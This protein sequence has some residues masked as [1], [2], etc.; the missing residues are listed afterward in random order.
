MATKGQCAVSDVQKALLRDMM[1]FLDDKGCS[2]HT[3]ASRDNDELFLLVSIGNPMLQAQEDDAAKAFANHRRYRF[4]TKFQTMS[5]TMQPTPFGERLNIH[6]RLNSTLETAYL[7]YNQEWVQQIQEMFES[8][9]TDSCPRPSN[10]MFKEYSEEIAGV[11]GSFMKTVDR[12]RM[13]VSELE[14]FF[15]IDDCVGQKLVSTYYAVHQASKLAEFRDGQKES[16]E[17]FREGHA[18]WSNFLP[19]LLVRSA[20]PFYESPVHEVR[21]YF[22]ALIAFYFAWLRYTSKAIF[23]TMPAAF[24]F[25]VTVQVFDERE[26]LTQQRGLAATYMISAICLS[27]WSVCYIKGWKRAESYYREVWG[28]KSTEEFCEVKRPDYRGE[29]KKNPLNEKATTKVYPTQSQMRV[30]V[31]AG[32]IFLAFTV[33]VMGTMLLIYSNEKTLGTSFTGI[34]FSLQIF[35]Y[36]LA[37]NLVSAYLVDLLNPKSHTDQRNLEVLVLF[38]ISFLSAYAN[39]CYRAYNK[40]WG[41]S[42]W[43]SELDCTKAMRPSLYQVVLPVLSAQVMSMLMPF[44]LFRY[45]L[46]DEEHKM[47]RAG[48]KDIAISFIEIQSKRPPFGPRELNKEMNQMAIQLGYV[49]LFGCVAPG[50]GLAVFVVF[51]VKIRVD[52]FKL[53]NVYQRVVPSRLPADGIGAW[54]TIIDTLAEVGR[55]TALAIP[56]FNLEYFDQPGDSEPL[57]ELLGAGPDGLTLLQKVVLWFAL[58][59]LAERMGQ[60]IS[61]CVNDVAEGTRLIGAKRQKVI[62]K[63]FAMLSKRNAP[64]K[65]DAS[66]SIQGWSTTRP[67]HFPANLEPKKADRTRFV[68][69]STEVNLDNLQQ[70]GQHLANQDL[71]HY[72]DQEDFGDPF[73]WSTYFG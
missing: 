4:Q 49:L 10:C 34:L 3:F 73:K 66:A 44:V 35:V 14:G 48:K 38:P 43:S 26:T 21:D 54:S 17:H 51:L 9:Q 25:S 13:L 5:K 6:Q 60:L 37:W 70:P 62:Q 47:R 72:V 65:S 18:T 7:E 42:C 28:V 11:R 8:F 15:D 22:G 27:I 12:V 71:W 59:E 19:S 63:V 67:S 32:A 36:Q 55:A 24:L 29:K 39:L 56:L 33:L 46:W 50:V 52:A 2:M 40:S 1:L 53:C 41:E 69:T 68:N 16:R 58:K 20:N 31:A 57:L 61:Y 23:W 45:K 64:Y 30:S